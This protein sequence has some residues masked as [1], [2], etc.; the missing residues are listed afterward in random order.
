MTGRGIIGRSHTFDSKHSQRSGQVKKLEKEKEARMERIEAKSGFQGVP[1]AQQRSSSSIPG[2]H[3]HA[4][5]INSSFE[6]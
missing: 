5:P 3:G 2:G 6:L 4:W 1:Q